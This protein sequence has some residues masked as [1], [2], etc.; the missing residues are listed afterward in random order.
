MRQPKGGVFIFDVWDTSKVQKDGFSYRF[1]EFKWGKVF[2][3][4]F[5]EYL[6]ITVKPNKGKVFREQHKVRPYSLSEIET[7]CRRY[8]YIGIRKDTKT[9]TTWYRF[10]KEVNNDNQ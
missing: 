8:G 10:E 2:V 1:K 3:E 4:P 5:F 9:W 6:N 7:I